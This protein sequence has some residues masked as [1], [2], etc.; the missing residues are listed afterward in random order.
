MKSIQLKPVD[1]DLIES[2]TKDVPELC[3]QCNT[4]AITDQNQYE[5]AAG[6]LKIVKGRYKE[7]ETQRKEIT[8]PIDEAKKKIMTLFKSPLDLLEKAE[9][10][11]KQLM[12]N[13]STEQE[14]KAEEER[15]RLQKIADDAAEKERKKLEKKIEKAIESGN[16]EKVSELQ[17]KKE[18][19][20]SIA[21]PVISAPV[22]K[23]SGISY[24]DKWYA[25]VIDDKLIPREYLIPNIDM[26][27]KVAALTKGTLSIP[28][29]QFKSEKII[30]SR[31]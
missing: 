4:L 1:V 24:R 21:V 31:G 19:I 9:S 14:R 18:S 27:N 25:V 26:L 10:K 12:V 3:N 7:L 23:P 16:E 17:E 22:E 20:E 6:L 30:A 5:Q 13:Y 28:G 15:K 29:V 2:E 8:S 11:I